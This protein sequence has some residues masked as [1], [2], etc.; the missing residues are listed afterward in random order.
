MKKLKRTGYGNYAL[1]AGVISIIIVLFLS[2]LDLRAIIAWS[3]SRMIFTGWVSFWLS[4]GVVFL[5]NE[6]PQLKQN[7]AELVWTLLVLYS[8]IILFL[9]ALSVIDWHWRWVMLAA[10][11]PPIAIWQL[12][13]NLRVLRGSAKYRPQPSSHI[14]SYP[15]LNFLIT[16][17]ISILIL[18]ISIG[19]KLDVREIILLCIFIVFLLLS[20]DY[21]IGGVTKKYIRIRL[22]MIRRVL[23]I[24]LLRNMKEVSGDISHPV[25]LRGITL[26]KTNL[27]GFDLRHA[28]LSG[29]DLEKANLS[30][31]NLECAKLCNSNFVRANLRGANLRK[32]DL[33]EAKLG[34]ANLKYAC[35]DQAN[36]SRTGLS[37]VNMRQANL[38]GANLI[39]ASLDEADL[40]QANLGDA[41]LSQAMM[42]ETD[43]RGANLKNA[44]LVEARVSK[45]NLY[46]ANLEGVD[47]SGA[48]MWRT[49]LRHANLANTKNLT[50]EQ[51]AEA[52]LDETTI[53]PDGTCWQ[54]PGDEGLDEE[55]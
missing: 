48:R 14:R 52:I 25:N 45:A 11:V 31:T 24:R 8:F 13:Q 26:W 44:N 36:L 10:L 17:G 50:S 51:L 1:L 34:H 43:L 21:S 49:D 35:L 28:N 15:N 46:G 32:A 54:P 41:D 55:V 5:I 30:Q 7:R 20:F 22:R 4:L 29:A 12:Y 33:S 19:L 23:G 53:M 42:L 6:L 37:S 40:R 3:P 38:R 27:R 16:V 2:V 9:A 39:G 18:I 47:L